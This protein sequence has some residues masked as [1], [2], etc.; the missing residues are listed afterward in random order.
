MKIKLASAAVVLA[1]S[2]GGASASHAQDGGGQAVLNA[3][4]E[5]RIS[6]P[7]GQR[8]IKGR[9]SAFLRL[10]PSDVDRGLVRVGALNLL[11]TDVPQSALVERSREGEESGALGFVIDGVEEGRYQTLAYDPQT[12]VL[13]GTLSG[14]ISH[15]SLTSGLRP[16]LEQ[17]EGHDF[18]G[19]A[20]E[21][22]LNIRVRLE[23]PLEASQGKEDIVPLRGEASLELEASPLPEY[24]LPAF[25]LGV[26]EPVEVDIQVGWAWRLEIA[27]RLCLQPVRIGRLQWNRGGRP[28]DPPQ[29]S[30]SYSGAGLNFGMPGANTQWSKADVLFT[31]REWKTVFNAAYSTLDSGEA[32][33]LRA[34]VQDDDCVEMFFVDELD[35][36]DTW[37]G[38]A[39]WSGG[40]AE[41]QIISSDENADN[42]IDLTH[43]AHEIGHAITLKHPGQGYPTA[44]APHRVDGSS[45]TLMCP[46]GFMNDNPPV[47]SEHNRDSV[48][49]PL[50]TFALKLAGPGTDCQDDPDCG[51]C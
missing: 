20:Q 32:N 49:N 6:S 16:E 1:A 8:S 44:A 28:W 30:V 21:A 50:F 33:G 42:G 3:E 13:K 15:S 14:R 47:N 31:V 48:Q 45:G 17:K 12:L 11:Y 4:L 39:T 38:G 43:L 46:S 5:S 9:L 18:E 10:D 41:T 22:R 34:S 36:N 19:V 23:E 40:L 26:L 35:P 25:Q 29:L 7:S 37:G 24:K 27:K 51:A 2:L